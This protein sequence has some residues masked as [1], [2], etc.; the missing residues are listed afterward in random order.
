M[1][2]LMQADYIKEII[3]KLDVLPYKAILF[4]GKWGIGKSYAINGALEKNENVCRISM[5]GLHNAGE[6]YH[7]ALFQLAL[8]NSLGGKVS[9]IAENILEGVSF[10]W[11][12]AEQAKEII[13]SIAK[14][15][16]ERELFLLLSK[17]FAK[18]HIVVIDDLERCSDEINL[19][20]VFGIVEELKQVPYLKVVMAACTGE[21]KELHK[22]IFE[23]Y[24]EKVIDRIYHITEIPKD[25]NWSDLRI[26]VGFIEDFLKLHDV[27]NLRTLEKAQRFYEDVILL[28]ENISDERFINEIRWI[29]FAIVV[30]STDKLYYKNP[31]ETTPDKGLLDIQNEL[32][33]RICNYLRG[34]MSSKNMVAEL[35]KYFA[36][37]TNINRDFFDV[38]YELFLEAGKK[39]NYYK[40]DEEI[41]VVLPNLRRKM[42]EADKLPELN[43][44]AD[45][46][47]VWSDV[48]EENNDDVLQEYKDKL[49]DILMKE[50]LNGRE[51]IL[52]YGIPMYH[53]SSEKIKI[54]FS[55]EISKMQV[56]LIET[57]VNYLH[58]TTK[59]QK[60]F[61]YSYKLRNCFDSFTY[62][63][64]IKH[65]VGCL[66]DRKS[67]PA[68]EIDETRY[69]TC[70][71]I[72]YVLYKADKDKFLQYCEELSCVCDHM[73]NHRIKEIVG[74]IIKK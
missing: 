31:D 66:Y 14:L 24:H 9:E 27:K 45:E 65:S 15:A 54:A 41:K 20:E 64:L 49:N 16:K 29:C 30:E 22:E 67:F 4:D 62:R 52:S 26:H 59:G 37:N 38:E 13:A 25:I 18:P 46:Y 60:A 56:V 58:E 39:V 12:K 5:F 73:S 63:D 17:G 3:A 2:V 19:E 72:M 10:V 69:H 68:D 71:N 36:Y 55:E 53:L 50:V 40:S 57:S 47:M 61:E 28:C 35:L 8:K 43:R 42:N 74:Q 70:F 34:V 32:E 7:E 6:I 51:N 44:F 11:K 1:E 21:M 23:R 33:H 48:L